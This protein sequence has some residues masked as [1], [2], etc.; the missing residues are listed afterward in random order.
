MNEKIIACWMVVSACG[1]IKEGK[2]RSVIRGGL[3]VEI[4]SSTKSLR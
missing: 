1:K 3:Q 4:V 2:G